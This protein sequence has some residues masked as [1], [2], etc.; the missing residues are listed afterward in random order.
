[1]QE[2]PAVMQWMPSYQNRTFG[3]SLYKKNQTVLL[4]RTF[5]KSSDVLHLV[6]KMI[7]TAF[8]GGQVKS[9]VIQFIRNISILFYSMTRLQTLSQ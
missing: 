3:L 6:N 9:C 2:T 8:I 5:T 1:M 4:L 7:N